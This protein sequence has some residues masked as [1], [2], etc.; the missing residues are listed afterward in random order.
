MNDKPEV[1]DASEVST[2]NKSEK[3]PESDSKDQNGDASETSPKP[4]A[5]VDGTGDDAVVIDG[6]EDSSTADWSLNFDQLKA[7]LFDVLSTVAFASTESP[8]R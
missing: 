2:E 4:T 8:L 5:P 1:I 7:I 6:P 3:N